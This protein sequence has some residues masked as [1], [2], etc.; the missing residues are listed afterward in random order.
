[1]G[2]L[3]LLPAFLLFALFMLWVAYLQTNPVNILIVCVALVIPA[4]LYIGY[5]GAAKQSEPALRG[6][7][8]ALLLVIT[9]QLSMVLVTFLDEDGTLAEAYV[10]SC[11][12]GFDEIC[13]NL[14]DPPVG[15]DWLSIDTLCGC[16][17][18]AVN[19]EDNSRNYTDATEDQ[20]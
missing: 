20:R 19:A 9:M 5:R 2:T 1:V 13:G 7:S 3:L 15:V 18:A 16:A 11:V 17:S 8:F 4:V 10:E 6:Y 12:L 14:Q